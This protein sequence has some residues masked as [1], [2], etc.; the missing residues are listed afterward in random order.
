M[1]LP[2]LRR[3]AAGKPQHIYSGEPRFEVAPF[4]RAIAVGER[5]G[6]SLPSKAAKTSWK[7]PV[8]PTG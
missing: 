2:R 3:K 6:A 4:S 8:E 1:I 5:F 7:S